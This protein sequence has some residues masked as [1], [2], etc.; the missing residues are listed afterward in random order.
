M[1]MLGLNETIDQLAMEDSVHWY[2][3]VLR[4]KDGDVLRR[5]LDFEAEGKRIKGWSKNCRELTPNGF[6]DAAFLPSTFLP[7]FLRI[8]VEVKASGPPH[9][10]RL[11]LG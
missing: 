4:R 7:H 9:V 3:H 6:Q 10:L 2:G 5:A 8:V 11:W 1:F